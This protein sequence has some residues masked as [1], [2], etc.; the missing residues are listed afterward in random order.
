[1][2]TRNALLTVITMVTIGGC[3]GGGGSD[4]G[5]TGN[6]PQTAP[7]PSVTAPTTV[8]NPLTGT[9]APGSP[10]KTLFAFAY[11]GASVTAYS[12]LPDGTS[13]PARLWLDP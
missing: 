9:A 3:G 12:V 11:A 7:T 8:T 6:A 2:K 1:M 10:T 13:G 4:G 5:T